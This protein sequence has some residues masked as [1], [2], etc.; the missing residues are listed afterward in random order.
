M[1]RIPTALAANRVPDLLDLLPAALTGDGPLC[2]LPSRP[3]P[4]GDW[5]EVLNLDLPTPAGTALLVATSGS[6]GSPRAVILPAS[7]LI[8][9]AQAALNRLGGPGSWLLALPTSAVG[10]LQ[11]ALRAVL[12]GRALAAIDPAVRFGPDSF[13]A[14]YAELPDDVHYTSL[15]PTQLYRL[16]VARGDALAALA[17][18]SA[19]LIGGAALDPALRAR[20]EAAG[21]RVVSTYGMTETAGGCVYD[22]VPLHGVRVESGPTGLRIG[23]AVVASGY[24]GLPER[25]AAVFDP[26]GWFQTNDIGSVD[27]RGRVQVTGRRDDILIS[28]GVNVSAAA[29]EAALRSCPGIADAAV[30]GRPDPEWGTSVEA[31]LVL[32]DRG[33]GAEVD[34]RAIRRHVA[35]RLGPAAAPRRLVVRPDLPRAHSGK[36]DR[37]AVQEALRE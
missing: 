17:S 6:T 10:G 13:L 3:A 12:S 18:F 25:S 14:A 29:V 9:S 28:G 23:G 20:A 11:V 1:T 36:L 19:V 24:H 2:V 21:V 8:A 31:V 15:V 26:P 33:P 5:A 30:S 22:G 27:D 35:D 4:G 32:T 37:R 34:D 16:L 7:A